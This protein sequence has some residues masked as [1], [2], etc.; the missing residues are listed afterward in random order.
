MAKKP[1]P[2][3]LQLLAAHE[4][5]DEVEQRASEPVTQI[6]RAECRERDDA[7]AVHR[8][9][10]ARQRLPSQAK[11]QVRDHDTEV[12]VSFEQLGS[13]GVEELGGQSGWDDEPV[14]DE[15]CPP[16]D[17]GIALAEVLEQVVGDHLGDVTGKPRRDD[18]AEGDPR[19]RSGVVGRLYR[20]AA[21]SGVCAAA[22]SSDQSVTS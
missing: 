10:V 2:A 1:T 13:G 16:V 20:A 15:L 22:D 3:I 14:D 9:G 18:H 8:T 11:R 4:I 5:L 6:E 7:D 19:K 12:P 21:G 17:G